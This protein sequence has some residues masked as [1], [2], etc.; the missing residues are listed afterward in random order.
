MYSRN[1][2]YVYRITNYAIHSP[3]YS[4]DS[5]S[6]RSRTIRIV[7]PLRIVEAIPCRAMSHTRAILY[8]TRSHPSPCPAALADP[9]NGQHWRHFCRGGA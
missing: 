7:A 2:M 6:H 3:D 5:H 1:P 4:A 9:P 8:A